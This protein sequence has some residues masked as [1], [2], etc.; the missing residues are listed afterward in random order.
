MSHREP[1]ATC[2]CGALRVS[3][4]IDGARNDLTIETAINHTIQV[5]SLCSRGRA[6]RA[7]ARACADLPSYYLMNANCQ[8]D[9]EH[10]IF[11]FY[12]IWN[13]DFA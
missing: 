1:A 8:E 3:G 2:A 6:T 11:H 7:R 5:R 12:L 9:D 13:N 10:E 4:A